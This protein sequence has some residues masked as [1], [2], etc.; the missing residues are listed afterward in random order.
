MGK[1]ILFLIWIEERFIK[2]KKIIINLAEKIFKES[3]LIRDLK[4]NIK[5]ELY[6]L[7][8]VKK[9]TP[10]DI[11]KFLNCQCGPDGCCN[12]FCFCDCII[13][14]KIKQLSG[15]KKINGRITRKFYKTGIIVKIY[16]YWLMEKI[17]ICLYSI[18]ICSKSIVFKY[19]EKFYELNEKYRLALLLMPNWECYYDCEDQC[20]GCFVCGYDALELAKKIR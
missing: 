18:R 20:Y 12:P 17:G 6:I 1:K 13:V 4:N 15:V 9:A 10:S 19:N 14:K 8:E 2:F 7:E 11:N 3:D 5:V 16:F